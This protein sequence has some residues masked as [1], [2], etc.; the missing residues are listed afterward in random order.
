MPANPQIQLS[1]A[2]GSYAYNANGYNVGAGDAISVRLLNT[3]GVE[4]WSLTAIGTDESSIAPTISV[5]GTGNSLRTF[6]AGSAGTTTIFQS[7]VTDGQ[8][9]QTSITFGVFVLTSGSARVIGTNQR[10]EGSSQYGWIT[11]VNPFIRA[12]GTFTLWTYHNTITSF[13]GLAR[14]LYQIQP[15][16]TTGGAFTLALP[17]APTT[18][19]RVD[20]LDVGATSTSTGIGGSHALTLSGAT[21]HIQNPHDFTV[22]SVSYVWGEANGDLGGST[23]SLIYTGTFWKVI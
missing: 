1:D 20:I 11:E 18:G 12:A 14:L 22:T 9:T 7:T 6:T 15:I 16:D 8:G 23:L 10:F 13:V 17:G 3:A 21:N 19:D 4:G 5:G 2:G